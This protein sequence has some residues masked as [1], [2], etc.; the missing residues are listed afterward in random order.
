[1]LIDVAIISIFCFIVAEK[2]ISKKITILLFAFLILLSGF[3]ISLRNSKETDFNDNF[4]YSSLR[5]ITANNNLFGVSK[6]GRISNHV[7]NKNSYYFGGTYF[8]WI[9][10]PIPRTLW[11]DKP[12]ITPGLIVRKDILGENSDN[13]LGGGIPPGLVAE[14]FMNFGFLG[15]IFIPMFLG[16]FVNFIFKKIKNLILLNKIKS[17]NPITILILLNV[18]FEFTFKIVGGSVTQS[19]ISILE[20]VIILKLLSS[21]KLY[22][23][24]KMKV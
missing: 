16:S 13:N 10:A 19:L 6:T 14:S 18:Y 12:P 3:I 2:K 20:A 4:L 17:I 22:Q 9:Y 7:L 1:V 21:I 23:I 24:W 8:T 5:S 11:E 15:I